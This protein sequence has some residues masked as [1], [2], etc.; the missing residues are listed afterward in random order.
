L[1][2]PYVFAFLAITATAQ[3]P[4]RISTNSL[5]D[6]TV[7]A[8]YSQT[9]AAMGGRTPYSWSISAGSLPASLQ[10]DAPSG[11]ISGTPASPGRATFTA[12]LMDAANATATQA[13]G[14]QVNPA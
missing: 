3:G 14:I 7:G 10:L 9:L 13:L 2:G 11:K 6:G 8:A 1:R 4:L 12:K 5:P